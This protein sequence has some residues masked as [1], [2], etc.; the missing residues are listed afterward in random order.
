MSKGLPASLVV[1]LIGLWLLIASQ[2]A[3]HDG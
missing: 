3:F 2:K 1:G